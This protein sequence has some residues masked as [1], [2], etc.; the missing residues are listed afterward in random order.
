MVE[1]RA[2]LLPCLPQKGYGKCVA[3]VRQL[4]PAASAWGFLC[5][6]KHISLSDN[7]AFIERH[8]MDTLKAG[9]SHRTQND[10]QRL[11]TAEATHYRLVWAW[12]N[13]PP[14]KNHYLP[15]VFQCVRKKV[16]LEPF[17]LT[18]NFLCLGFSL[19][20]MEEKSGHVSLLWRSEMV[21]AH[22]E[23]TI[24]DFGWLPKFMSHIRHRQYSFRRTWKINLETKAQT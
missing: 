8:T 12:L 1:V 10:P 3:P 15:V 18:S 4:Q 16:K 7:T 6:H 9:L 17:S 23:L 13:A 19:F 14:Y 11:S 5:L 21:Q 20:G 22:W 24:C 2:P